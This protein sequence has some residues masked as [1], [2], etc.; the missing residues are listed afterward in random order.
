M[1]IAGDQPDP[2]QA[3][4]HQVSEERVPRRF[5]LRGCDL[6]PEDLA[7]SVAVDAGRDEHDG[8]D[9]PAAFSDLHRQRVGGDEGE[10]PGLAQGAV[11]ELGHVFIEV[12]G[13]PRHL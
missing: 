5:G 13:H 2:G 7:V 11:A 3:A 6:Q 8:V 10:R 12:G 4:G 1:G 9:H